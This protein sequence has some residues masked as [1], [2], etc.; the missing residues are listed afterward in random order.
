MRHCTVIVVLIARYRRLSLWR[1]FV[2]WAFGSRGRGRPRPH[3]IRL[4][5][6]FAVC[7]MNITPVITT[8]KEVLRPPFF[9]CCSLVI[10]FLQF[11]FVYCRLFISFSAVWLCL[12]QFAYV[13]FATKYCGVFLCRRAAAIR[14]LC[15]A[16]NILLRFLGAYFKKPNKPFFLGSSAGSADSVASTTGAD[17]SSCD[18]SGVHSGRSSIVPNLS[19]T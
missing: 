15:F 5:S 1:G 9:V 3:A 11:G 10:P 2:V 19:C 13:P 16:P 7:K 18:C 14:L 8:K 17:A 12:L 4:H 6:H